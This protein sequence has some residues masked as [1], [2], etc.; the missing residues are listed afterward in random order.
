MQLAR[1]RGLHA[2]RASCAPRIMAADRVPGVKT[3]S[4]APVR[5]KLSDEAASGAAALA[6]A[7][8]SQR[9]KRA[10]DL[11]D[12]KIQST[13][14]ASGASTSSVLKLRA[15]HDA[16]DRTIDGQHLAK[17]VVARAMRRRAMRLDDG[18]RPLRLL[19]AGPYGVGKT[20][21]ATAVRAT[22]PLGG[23]ALTP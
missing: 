16:I 19:F 13:H 11:D 1:R 7:V 15:I 17:D 6:A 14:K 10:A 22:A 18:E 9:A 20:A 4:G 23:S 3:T 21:M 5:E 12:A 8:A 2:S